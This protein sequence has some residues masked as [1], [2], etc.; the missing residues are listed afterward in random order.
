MALSRAGFSVDAVCPPRHPLCRVSVM[1]TI[2]PHD[3]FAP[4][5]SFADAIAAAAPDLLIPGDEYAFRYVQKLYDQADRHVNRGEQFR[6]LIER[7]LGPA[8]SIHILAA[9]AAV[10]RE[11]QQESIRVPRTRVVSNI[12]ELRSGCEQLLFPLVLKADGSSSGEGVRVVRTFEEAK[13][14]FRVLQS[15]PAFIRV[16][17]RALIDRDMRSVLPALL[18]QR[19]TVNAQ[20]FIHGN[21]A[22]SLVAC[23]EGS[24]RAT[25]HFEVIKKRL[26]N[27]PASVMRRM[28]HPQL[29]LFISRITRRLKLSGLHG[30]DFLLEKHTGNPYLIELNPRPTQVGHLTLGRGHDLPAALYA[31][32]TGAETEEAPTVTDND[33]I[34]LF[35]QEWTRNPQSVFLHSAYHDIPW[36]EPE[37]VRAGALGNRSWASWYKGRRWAS[38]L[39]AEKIGQINE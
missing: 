27:G 3:A 9:R 21:D 16:L 7:S 25:L 32:V 33:T 1:K 22:T 5:Q 24:V 26:R 15:P 17:K 35:P 31:A 19:N 6:A 34:A 39:L 38:F 28:E 11:A 37:L 36:E 4:L 18:R 12:A 20:E 23:W 29:D 10:M 14:A 8:E 30:F 2:Y 13:K